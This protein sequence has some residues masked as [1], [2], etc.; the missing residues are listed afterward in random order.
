MESFPL[1]SVCSVWNELKIKINVDILLVK[2]MSLDVKCFDSLTTSS[3]YWFP[4]WLSVIM[5]VLIFTFFIS[6]LINFV[7][8]C[9]HKWAKRIFRYVL[10]LMYHGFHGDYFQSLNTV[11]NKKKWLLMSI[12]ATGSAGGEDHFAEWSPFEGAGLYW[13]SKYQCAV[14]VCVCSLLGTS[15]HQ[16]HVPFS[17]DSVA[18]SNRSY[19]SPTASA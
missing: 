10:L 9:R 6:S 2:K 16:I 1:C 13:E 17:H 11:K 4:C 15:E 12:S 18:S 8:F 7:L 14:F 3:C 19:C 5:T